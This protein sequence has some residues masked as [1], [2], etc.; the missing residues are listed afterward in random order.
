ML[1]L[2]RRRPYGGYRAPIDFNAIATAALSRASTIVPRWLPDGRRQGHEWVSRNPRRA[3]NSIGSFKI[4]LRTG[5]WA[6]FAVDGARGNDLIS[7]KAY[8]LNVNQGS[9]A[10]YLAE[11]IGQ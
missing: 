5:R 9:A 8:L 2:S 6:D 11:E 10:R 3:D 4:N 1:D 7:L